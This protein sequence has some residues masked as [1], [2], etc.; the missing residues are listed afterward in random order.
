MNPQN[1]PQGA[2]QTAP[3]GGFLKSGAQAIAGQQQAIEEAKNQGNET[4]RF[5]MKNTTAINPKTGAPHNECAIVFLD[6][7]VS[8]CVGFYEHLVKTG[9]NYSNEGCPGE[10][11]NCPLCESGLKKYYV[12]F[13]TVFVLQPWQS[14]DGK[15]SGHG[16][17]MLLPI[18][19]TQFEKLKQ[20]LDMAEQMHGTIRGVYMKMK[21]DTTNAQSAAI[22]E[23]S[24]LDN[25]SLFAVYSEEDLVNNFGHAAILAQDNTILKPANDAITAINY[26][27]EFKKPDANDLRH[28]YGG[29]TQAGAQQQG[30]QQPA[31]GGQAWG[32]QAAP[33]GG[34][35]GSQPPQGQAPQQ[36]Q[37]GG[38]PIPGQQPMGQQELSS[39]QAAIPAQQPKPRTAARPEGSAP[40]PGNQQA[41]APAQQTAPAQP[42]TTAPLPG[43][44][45]AQANPP[46][47]QQAA[48]Q[49]PQQ[50]AAPPRRRPAPPQAGTAQNDGTGDPNDQIPMGDAPQQEQPAADP[51]AGQ[52]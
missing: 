31:Q 16:S 38:A 45:S 52:E 27:E 39:Q 28:R 42:Q 50:Q 14:K 32:G 19:S 8:D 3:T 30:F 5:R 21:R 51:Y 7:S 11:D 24:L 36:A 20:V 46:A 41:E 43:Q 44:P 22:G 37:P 10:W 47:N 35:Q 48:P 33:A 17:K 12:L 25:A 23:P 6:Q 18:K 40:L 26:L 13:F 49:Q 34:Q 1:G 15:R 4:W 9:Q 29:I 2:P